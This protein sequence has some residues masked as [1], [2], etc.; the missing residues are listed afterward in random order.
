[1]FAAL[2]DV[3]AYGQVVML[4]DYNVEHDCHSVVLYFKPAVRMPCR[5][6][7]MFMDRESR[8]LG[9]SMLDDPDSLFELM[10]ASDEIR[11]VYAA[12]E[13]H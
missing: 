2:H 11:A 10:D 12:D 13:V 9:F 7:M 1:M 5:Y 6:E 3:Y 4:Q 8:D